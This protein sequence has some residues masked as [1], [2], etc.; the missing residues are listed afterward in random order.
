MNHLKTPMFGR[1]LTP[2]VDA[3]AL[4]LHRIAMDGRSAA[5][6]V[7]DGGGRSAQTLQAGVAELQDQ[8]RTKHQAGELRPRTTYRPPDLGAN[9]YAWSGEERPLRLAARPALIM[10][11]RISRSK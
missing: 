10:A 7:T 8:A 9:A 1:F 3:N 2:T 11:T 5:P 6:L 4:R